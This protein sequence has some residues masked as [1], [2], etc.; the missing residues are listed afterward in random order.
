MR[1]WARGTTLLAGGL[2]LALATGLVTGWRA[3]QRGDWMASGLRWL[4]VRQGIVWFDRVALAVFA[5][6]V[7]LSAWRWW[8]SSARVVTPSSRIVLGVIAAVMALRLLLPLGGPSSRGPNLVLISIDTLRADR[9]S[10]FGYARPTSPAIDQKLAALG[11][12]FTQASSVSPKTTPS[13][14]SML[15]ALYPTVHGVTMWEGTEERAV[16]NP[17]VHTLAEL[18][19]NAGYRTAAFTGGAP[20]HRT[21]GF[22][23]GFEIYRHGQQL[24]RA[25]AWL[26]ERA[27]DKFFLFFHTY[28][29]HDP[30]A[31]PDEYVEQFAPGAR[32]PLLDAARRVRSQ[33]ADWDSAHARYW[34]AVDRHDPVVTDLLGKLYDAGIRVM[35]DRTVTP[36]L[37][38]LDRL[39]LRDNTLV[40][41]V[42][43]HGEAFLEHDAFLHD[44]VYWETTHVPWIMRWPGRLPAGRRI[45]TPV[46]MIDLMPTLLDLLDV[47]LPE[48]VQGRSVAAAARGEELV[49]R[50]VISEYSTHQAG[51]FQQAVR[52]GNERLVLPAAPAR[53]FDLAT[54]PGEQRDVLADRPER[55]AALTAELDRWRTDCARLVPRFSPSGTGVAPDPDTLRRLR[56][57]GYVE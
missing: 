38:A 15:T 52:I 34:E 39:G 47:P 28:D 6:V 26:E 3:A 2:L 57:L 56:A 50:P 12:V 49:P 35:D 21:R 8:R 4:A 36:L 22:D 45:T 30:Y 43:D 16:L 46:S 53:L 17:R 18:L 54:D 42:S 48:P 41:L 9:L 11:V 5:A 7:V 25:L 13:H 29:V 31:P 40:V 44:D 32:G 1:A 55:A 23:H 14:M 10:C 37:G 19:Q 33:G 27:A 20:M 24:P 51:A